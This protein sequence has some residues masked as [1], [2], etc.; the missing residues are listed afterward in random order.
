VG[1]CS[2][3]AWGLL[4]VWVFHLKKLFYFLLE[5]PSYHS[6]KRPGRKNSRRLSSR[7]EGNCAAG[8]DLFDSLPTYHSLRL[9]FAG[10]YLVYRA[11][12][13]PRSTSVPSRLR[14][15]FSF[16]II[17]RSRSISIEWRP[18]VV[19]VDDDVLSVRYSIPVPPP[20]GVRHGYLASCGCSLDFDYLGT[21]LSIVD[22]SSNNDISIG[23]MKGPS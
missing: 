3:C 7:L 5:N 9:L 23:A 20:S 21:G 2:E 16:P 6:A 14:P 17:G 19:V 13:R 10:L 15:G 11:P 4:T 22:R 18:R 1:K 8:S 12:V